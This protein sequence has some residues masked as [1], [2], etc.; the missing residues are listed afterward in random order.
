[1]HDG[2]GRK[3]CPDYKAAVAECGDCYSDPDLARFIAFRTARWNAE[4]VGRRVG[5]DQI[6]NAIVAVGIARANLTDEHPLRVLDFGGGCGIHYFSAQYA[7]AA[8]LKVRLGVLDFLFREPADL[9]HRALPV[10]IQV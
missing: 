9:P 5:F 3:I 8:P 10:P 6:S 7:F 1:M 2:F 4:F